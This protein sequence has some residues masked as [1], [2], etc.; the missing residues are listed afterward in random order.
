MENVKIFTVLIFR[1]LPNGTRD[2]VTHFLAGTS[3]QNALDRISSYDRRFFE[4]MAF[5]NTDEFLAENPR[6]CEFYTNHSRKDEDISNDTVRRWVKQ[7]THPSIE[8]GERRCATFRPVTFK[9]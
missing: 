6:T 5:I 1:D 9:D 7:M 2:C 8:D 4:G 3:S